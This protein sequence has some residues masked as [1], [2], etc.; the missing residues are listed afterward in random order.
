[1][2]SKVHVLDSGSKTI[3][4]ADDIRLCAACGARKETVIAR[5]VKNLDNLD[6]WLSRYGLSF[7]E[8]KFVTMTLKS[9]TY[10][11]GRRVVGPWS[12]WAEDD[13]LDITF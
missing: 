3:V 5:Q 7:S 10:V 11:K 4:Y 12:P 1:M 2:V 13:L 9:E 8:T 6:K